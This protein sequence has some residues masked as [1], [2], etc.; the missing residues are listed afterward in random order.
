[1]TVK[2]PPVLFDTATLRFETFRIFQDRPWN[3]TT[4]ISLFLSEWVVLKLNCRYKIRRMSFSKPPEVHISGSSSF[5]SNGTINLLG[6]DVICIWT[7]LSKHV[8]AG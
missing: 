3:G 5:K 4:G 2:A 7:S 8:I 6:N 1:M